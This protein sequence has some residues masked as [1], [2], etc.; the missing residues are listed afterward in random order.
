M[1]ILYIIKENN[2]DNI[3]LR[4]SL[5]SLEQYGKNVGRVYVAGHCPNWLSDKVIK[6]PCEDLNKGDNISMVQ[7]SQNIA[8]KLLYAVE[9]S[10]IGEEF[11]VSMDD[12]FYVSPTDFN[13]YP[14]YAN[15]SVNDGML[16]TKTNYH[17]SYLNFLTECRYYLE[18]IGLST[19]YFTLHRNMHV[20]RRALQELKPILDDCFEHDYPFELFVL[21]NNYRF[22]KG[23]INPCFVKD[24]KIYSGSEWWKTSSEY[25]DVFSTGDFNSKPGLYELLK[26][27]YNKKSK[28]EN[29]SSHM[30]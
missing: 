26:G 10:D 1:D 16:P 8:Y 28:Y 6:I 18:S 12:H 19:F 27:L 29:N 14:F 13:K 25:T 22:S 21:I 9:H 17:N 23:E 3:E 15:K 7:K 11:L 20:S 24:V 4:C 30:D 5:R 2:L